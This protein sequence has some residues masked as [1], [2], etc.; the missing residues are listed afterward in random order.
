M[1]HQAQGEIVTPATENAESLTEA[2]ALREVHHREWY[3]L[4]DRNYIRGIHA[5]KAGGNAVDAGAEGESVL[6]NA[7]SKMHDFKS[8]VNEAVDKVEDA[9]LVEG[10]TFKLQNPEGSRRQQRKKE[11]NADNNDTVAKND[12]INKD[13]NVQADALELQ[14]RKEQRGETKPA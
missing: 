2:A 1:S 11:N 7:N 12:P 5:M 13:K 3:V 9:T 4:F 6:E 8:T 10:K 14:R